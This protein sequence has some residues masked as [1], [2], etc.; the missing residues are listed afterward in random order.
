MKILKIEP[1]SG[2]SGDMFLGALSGLTPTESLF[3]LSKMLGL[4]NVKI[5]KSSVKRM[6]INCSKIHVLTPR[7][8]P[9]RSLSDIFSL[10]DRASLEPSVKQLSKKIFEILGKAEARAHD[11]HINSI[12][13]HEVGA[14]DAIIDIVGSSLLLNKIDYH[15]VI[16]EPICTGFGTVMCEHGTIPVPAPAT[17]LILEGMPVFPGEVK[18]EMT[19]PTGAAI[20]KA[21]DP[22][23]ERR[24]T[25]IT[26][27]SNGA[28]SNNLKYRANF[29]RMSTGQTLPESN[30]D[31]IWIIQTNLDDSTGEILGDFLQSKLMK[32]GALDVAITP[33]IMKK[34]RPGAKLEVLSNENTLQE[35]LDTIL[36]NTS[37]F[38]I[39]YF[40]AA[41][42]IIPHEI[43]PVKTRYGIIRSKKGQSPSGEIRISPEYEDCKKAATDHNVSLQRV[44]TEAIS[45]LNAVL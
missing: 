27:S 28:G 21:L 5:E 18:G 39:R 2:L 42:K 45:S 8:S 26:G 1:F 24:Q 6:G 10:I 29:L 35:L 43:I 20:L 23:F 17:Q 38:G 22:S 32:A 15:A 40:Q 25:I 34:G 30:A 33:I 3:E 31:K 36:N 7:E 44:Y 9:R 12:H 41:R 4:E 11:T 16:C 13:F 14:C 37:T 19:T